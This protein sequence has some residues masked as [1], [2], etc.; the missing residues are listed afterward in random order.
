VT[1][2]AAGVGVLA[3]LAA[4]AV[5]FLSP[6]VLPLVPAYLSAV[7]GV[8]PAD[9]EHAGARRVLPPSLAFVAS[10]SLIFILLGLGATTVGSALRDHH[11]TLDKVAAAVIVAMGVYFVASAFVARLNRSWHVERLLTRAGKGGPV[12]AG[13]AFAIA[14]TPCVGPILSAAAL[15]ASVGHAA[16]LLGFYSAGLAIPFLATALA[17]GRMTSAFD[18]VKRH[19]PIVI[20]VSGAILITVG[21][22]I[23]TGELFVLNIKAQQLLKR[24]GIDF[25]SSV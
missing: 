18:V 11:D 8:A 13:A 25:F 2:P 12:V 24:L 23:W 9:L 15:T 6:C 14:W 1:D 17:F 19:F 21:V 20:G 4:G 16:V 7:V 22:L 10:F 3:A 5:S